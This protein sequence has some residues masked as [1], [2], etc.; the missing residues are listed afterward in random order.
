MLAGRVLKL[1]ES[2]A[3]DCG[4]G[5]GGGGGGGCVL[6]G[7]LSFTGRAAE[8][9]RCQGRVTA[10]YCGGGGRLGGSRSSSRCRR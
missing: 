3:T 5:G 8:A 7:S 6:F 1:G 2:T 10:A 9:V 4:S